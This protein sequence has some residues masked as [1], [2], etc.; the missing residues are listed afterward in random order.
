MTL[1]L[2]PSSSV[3]DPIGRQ[4]FVL[5][6][7]ALEEA[8]ALVGALHDVEALSPFR[9]MVTPGGFT[10]S[11]ALTN[12]GRFGWFT[13]QR[14]Y[15]YTE[16]DPGSGA[17]WPEMP[18]VLLRL[19]QSAAAA[20]G[21]ANF[22]PDACLINRYVPGA[23]LTL[24]QDRNEQSFDHPIVSISL[25]IPAVFLFGGTER[26]DRAARVPLRHGDVAVWGGVDRLRYHGILPLKPAT[27]PLLGERR[28]NFTLRKAG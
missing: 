21:F 23:R 3:V 4:A 26:G 8:P 18:A 5:R 20:V 10:M 9:H 14:G 15:R 2:F 27:H 25:G 19:A 12:C 13:D 28:L 16:V 22:E 6:E 24:H 11:V 1:P 17:P 7:F